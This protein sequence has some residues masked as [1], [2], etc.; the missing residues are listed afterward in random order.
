MR[1]SATGRAD[2]DR[3]RGFTLIELLVVMTIIGLMSAAV[4]LALPDG[5]GDLVAEAERFAARVHA[6]GERAVLDAK[7]MAVRVTAAGYGFDRRERGEWQP[8]AEE[9][10][11]DRAWA[12]GTR[13]GLAQGVAQRVTFDTT[14]IAE[15]ARLLLLRG[16]D[17][18]QVDLRSDGT[19][20]VIR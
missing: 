7:P 10:F 15:P 8:L 11:A 3:E 19:V 13:A 5:R 17:Q 16:D 4:V 14:G 1:T 12:E 6:A 9:P 20:H 2:R 18:V